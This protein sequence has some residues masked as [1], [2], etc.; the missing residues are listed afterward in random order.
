MVLPGQKPIPIP[1]GATEALDAARTLG[2]FVYSKL[3]DWLIKK[4]NKS[5]APDMDE[6]PNNPRTIGILDIFGFEIFVENTFEQLCINYANEKLQQFFNQHT[7]KLEEKIY[8]E[9]GIKFDKVPYI[10]NQPV[11]DLIEKKSSGI[12]PMIDEELMVPKGTDKTLIAKMHSKH[13]KNKR[14]KQLRKKP[15][16]FVVVHYGA[17]ARLCVCLCF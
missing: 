12:L 15:T 3:F 9:E 5:V 7:F 14:Y 16:N 6:L 2:K 8:T 17:R 11:L 1:L 10:D 13:G 4:V